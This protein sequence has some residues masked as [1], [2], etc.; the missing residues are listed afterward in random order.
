MIRWLAA[1]IASRAAGV[2]E[3][4]VAC[5]AA[6]QYAVRVCLRRRVEVANKED[7]RLLILVALFR[8]RDQSLTDQGR[9]G[10][11]GFGTSRIKMLCVGR[12]PCQ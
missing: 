3:G 4:A 8:Q 10:G 11:A 9:R 5:P 1:L 12:I 6:R 2:D 7:Q